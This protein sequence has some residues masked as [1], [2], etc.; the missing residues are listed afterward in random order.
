[1]AAGYIL[2]NKIIHIV[3]ILHKTRVSEL[4]SYLLK[5]EAISGKLILATTALAL[6]IANTSMKPVYDALWHTNLPIGFG[7]WVLSLDL[8]HW[9]N[10]G[11]M[12]IFF[13]VVGLELKRELV[14]GK[15]RD[16]GTALLPIA[17]AI[18]GMIVPAII[19]LAI[20]A[21][22]ETARGWAIPTATDI[23]IA[24]GFLALLGDRIPTSLRLFLLTL[25]IVDDVGTVIVIGLFYSV[26]ANF[27]M[28]LAA[29]LLSGLVLLLA[30]MKLLN[31]PVFIIAGILLWLTLQASGIHPSIAGALLGLLAPVKRRKS[32]EPLAERLERFTIPASTLVVV[33]LFAF[34]NTGI[35]L[36]F[37]A[38]PH[39]AAL[40]LT[41]GIILG[42]VAGKTIG[43]LLGS[44]L[45]IKLGFS[46]LPTSTN[47]M[48]ILG[49]GLL[50]GIGFTVSIFVTELAF[51][52][53]QLATISKLSIFAASA[54]SAVLGLLV[55]RY[56][57][58]KKGGSTTLS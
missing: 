34:A 35:P 55:L 7:D 54:I 14:K 27:A 42:L 45:I 48:H 22:L 47:W 36:S 6:L 26:D 1:M 49:A 58:V 43:V 40:P 12:A 41:G 9:I 18:G 56:L 50:A 53:E 4:T 15:L 31:M 28:L 38:F 30:K 8:R 21:G 20:N 46:S 2:K 51:T 52:G 10:E 32:G 24:I 17:A 11:L 19:F 3:K 5:D 23:A 57:A 37:D 13:L 39:D 16:R 25:A 33:P 29:A 44:W